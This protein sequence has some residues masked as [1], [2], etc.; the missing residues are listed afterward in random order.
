[1]P[2]TTTMIPT[3]IPI[4]TT[5]FSST[6][7]SMVYSSEPSSATTETITFPPTTTSTATPDISTTVIDTTTRRRRTTTNKLSTTIMTTVGSVSTT[8]YTTTTTTTPF[9]TSTF[10]EGSSMTATNF[11]TSSEGTTIR[12]TTTDIPASLPTTLPI[13]TAS[14]E[15]I[16]LWIALSG[17]F[18]VLFTLASAY[19]LYI[20]VAGIEINR[21]L[22]GI[23]SFLTCSRSKRSNDQDH[24]APTG[25]NNFD[26]H[27]MYYHLQMQQQLK[28]RLRPMHNSVSSISNNSSKAI[29]Q[30]YPRGSVDP[31]HHSVIGSGK[32]LPFG[33]PRLDLMDD[34]DI[35]KYKNR[36]NQL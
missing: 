8:L 18:I 6:L 22:R 13:A 16:A 24:A 26:P 30:K 15:S 2:N 10:T 31:Y 9:P 23:G 36:L 5:T 11:P 29:R 19:A 20:Y 14:N 32:A 25:P 21:A 34:I 7:S 27:D 3:T 35:I 17:I 12:T 28:N 1:M 4:S 33:Q